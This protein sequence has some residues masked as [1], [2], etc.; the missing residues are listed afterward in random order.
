MDVIFGLLRMRQSCLL[1][2]DVCTDQFERSDRYLNA[3]IKAT[4]KTPH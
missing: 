2:K 1:R 3:V 4:F